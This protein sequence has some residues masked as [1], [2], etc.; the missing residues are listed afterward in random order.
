MQTKEEVSLHRHTTNIYTQ[1][2]LTLGEEEKREGGDVL[3]IPLHLR[4]T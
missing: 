3:Q 4:A 2:F 1:I